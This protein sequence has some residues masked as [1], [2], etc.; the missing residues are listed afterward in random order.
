MNNKIGLKLA[1]Q[2]GEPVRTKP[3]PPESPGI[4]YINEDEIDYVRQVLKARSPFRFYGPDVQHM[5]DK[6][7]E[8]FRKLYGVKYA[9][10][11]SSGTEALYISLAALGVGPGDEV[12]L[13]GYLWTSCLNAI[14]RLGAIPKLVDINDTFNM[15]PEDLEQKIGPHSKVILVIHMSGLPGDIEDIIGIAQKHGLKVLEDCAQSNGATLNGKPVGTFGDIGIF[16]F[17]INKSITAGEGGMI[18]C[19]DDHL[20]K[21]CFGIHDL[22]YARNEV[23]ILMDTSCD[24]QYHMWGCGARMSELT[25]AV[26]LAQVAKLKDINKAMRKAK[27]EIR[28]GIETIEGIS[29]R[30]VNDPE[31]DSGAFIISIFE[32]PQICQSFSEAL[33]AEGIRGEGYAIPYLTMKNWGLHWYFNNKSL[34]NRR[35]L[36]ENGWPW[37]LSQNDFAQHYQYGKG[38]L[39]VCDDM[40]GRSSL[41]K[42]QSCLTREDIDDIVTAFKKVAHHLL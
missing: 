28:K 8:E 22:G 33:I 34:V 21:R 17:Q 15:S 36:H 35:S 23:G 3:L 32:T 41:L 30:R 16:S 29:L 18:V 25:G 1:I 39:P 10:G 26:L 2:G 24:E 20:Y 27:W 40:A 19:N 7:E 6:L 31:G 11:V 42:V 5:C 9:L 12:L 13:S 4:H 14:I 38:T 37:T